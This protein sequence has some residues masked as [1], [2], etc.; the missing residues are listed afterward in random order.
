MSL[1]QDF[2]NV[3]YEVCINFNGFITA[4]E[5]QKTDILRINSILAIG[6]EFSFII[7]IPVLIW[8]EN[9]NIV[10]GPDIKHNTRE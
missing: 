5:S 8:K 3:I 7:I 2:L 9:N 6:L 10:I 4:A 1:Y